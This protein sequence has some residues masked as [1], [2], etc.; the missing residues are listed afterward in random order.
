MTDLAAFRAVYADWKL[1]KTRGVVQVVFELPLEASGQ[2]YDV[3][4][5]MPNPG[6]SVW[7]GIARL[8]VT[9]EEA[10]NKPTQG[11]AA[12]SVVDPPTRP[13]A[14]LAR[15]IGFLCNTPKF[16][17][18]LR[19]RGYAVQTEEEAAATIRSICNVKTRR[20]ILPNTEAA[21]AWEYLKSKFLAWDLAP[22]AGM[23]P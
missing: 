5:G 8:E 15:Q 7:C 21:V 23:S 14:S 17:E 3:L 4:G 20:D 1:V 12:V 22:R 16:Q 9:K 11:K 13:P 6:T 19:Q 18:F 2:A 10:N